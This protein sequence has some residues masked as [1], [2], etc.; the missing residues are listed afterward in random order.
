VAERIQTSLS[1]QSPA[2]GQLVF[3][4]RGKGASEPAR[5]LDTLV[6]ALVSQA[7]ADRE[8]RSDGLYTAISEPPHVGATPL[9]DPRLLYTGAVFVGFSMF[10]FAAGGLAW[11]RMASVKKKL[12]RE[13]QESLNPADWNQA[14]ETLARRKF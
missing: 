1:V 9:E 14:P 10:S 8:R 13:Q 3:E 7:N 6:T 5:V 11:R 4:L 12:E 2:N